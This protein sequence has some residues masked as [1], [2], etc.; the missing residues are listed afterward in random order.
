MMAYKRAKMVA[1][2]MKFQYGPEDWL[3]SNPSMSLFAEIGYPRCANH[4]SEIVDVQPQS[5]PTLGS[6]MEFVIP[7]SG[8][9][10]GEIDLVVSLP[11]NSHSPNDN[12][13]GSQYVDGLGYALVEKV[14]FSVGSNTIEEIPG[15]WLFIENELMTPTN[16]RNATRKMVDYQGRE[17]S[18]ATYATEDST[19]AEATHK[20]FEASRWSHQAQASGEMPFGGLTDVMQNG[21]SVKAA[22]PVLADGATLG[23]LLHVP[24]RFY[25]TKH[26]STYLRVAA[27][28]SANDVRVSVVLRSYKEILRI[29][30]STTN[31][32]P[33][34]LTLALRCHFVHVTAPEQQAI[35]EKEHVHIM[36][37]IQHMS[38]VFALQPGTDKYEDI[39]LSFLHPVKQ[40]YFILRHHGTSTTANGSDPK[41]NT[42]EGPNNG[43]LRSYFKLLGGVKDIE[44]RETTDGDFAFRGWQLK[45]NGQDMHT[46]LDYVERDYIKNKLMPRL[47]SQDEH[48]AAAVEQL[49]EATA[50]AIDSIKAMNLNNASDLT[51]LA[52]VQADLSE[53][54]GVK[55]PEVYVVPL[56]MD[57]ENINPSGHINFSKVTHA[58]LRV[59][60]SSTST[61]KVTCDIFAQGYNWLTIKNGRAQL[62]FA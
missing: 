45:L 29:K 24:L 60:Y 1:A 9:L 50:N 19:S 38:N 16:I 46:G 7:K 53:A 12:Q 31:T 8:D 51:A 52:G 62:T 21:K 20:A 48:S 55:S 13:L 58:T 42:E 57:P 59:Y 43:E 18:M 22:A 10:L 44:G 23:K 39:K 47:H 15:E 41:S 33:P 4:T 54:V 5:N 11:N 61:S 6:R 14:V 40:L 34:N 35:M 27:L 49:R 32:A 56:S 37:T 2:H 3:L 25:F 36:H 28:S 30:H 17:G 26:P